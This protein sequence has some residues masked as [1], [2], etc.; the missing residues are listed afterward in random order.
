M[1]YV[2]SGELGESAVR[3]ALHISLWSPV[4]YGEPDR[5]LLARHRQEPPI[6][7]IRLVA[8]DR[9]DSYT[10]HR[11]MDDAPA[12]RNDID[13]LERSLQ[14]L[15]KEILDAV[16]GLD[17]RLRNIEGS[18]ERLEERTSKLSEDAPNIEGRMNGR[19][20]DLKGDIRELRSAKTTWLVLLATLFFGVV[21]AYFRDTVDF[22]KSLF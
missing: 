2:R 7:T 3:S 16:S 10:H 6:R 9:Q 18:S 19:M 17:G 4:D 20:E 13:R 11:D 21:T 22:V 14:S 12:T 1:S 8:I 5:R 15:R